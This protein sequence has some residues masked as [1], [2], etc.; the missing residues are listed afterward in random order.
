MKVGQIEMTLM[1]KKSGRVNMTKYL[2]IALLLQGCAAT[3]PAVH[4]RADGWES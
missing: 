4:W 2:L 1:N 3:K